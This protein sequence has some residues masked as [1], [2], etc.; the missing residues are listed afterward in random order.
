[1]PPGPPRLGDN[2][3]AALADT[4]PQRK[5]KKREKGTPLEYPSLPET[6]APN[7]RYVVITTTD[8]NKTLDEYSCFAI[9]RGLDLISKDILSISPLRDGSLLLLVKDKNIAKK[10]TETKELV[11]VCKVN[12]KLHEH[13]NFTKGTIYAPYLNKLPESEIIKELANDGVVDVYKYE[14]MVDGKKEKTGVML[15]TFDLY[16]VPTKLQVTYHKSFVREYYPNPMRCKQCQLL[17]HTQKR[18]KNLPACVNCNLPPHSPEVCTRTC[19]AN[20]N[21]EHPSSSNK[22]KK[23]KQQKDILKIKTKQKCTMREAIRLHRNQTINMK[24][25][26]SYS[27]TLSNNNTSIPT[28]Q[29]E[30]TKNTPTP[31]TAQITSNTQTTNSINRSSSPQPQESKHTPSTSRNIV[32]PSSSNKL[33]NSSLVSKTNNTSLTTTTCINTNLKLHSNDNASLTSKNNKHYLTAT[34]TNSTNHSQYS[35][36]NTSSIAKNN[37]YLSP[38][39][40]N[41]HTSVENEKNMTKHNTSTPKTDPKNYS[42]Y[43]NTS[44]KSYS[45]KTPNRPSDSGSVHE[46]S[47]VQVELMQTDPV[48]D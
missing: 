34:T 35:S 18:C 39:T 2:Q 41:K 16:T 5:R 46:N 20:C 11:G 38:S 24:N 43:K 47:T 23:Y 7:P 33:S 8:P 6:Q 19:C 25:T 17:G 28:T 40:N 45:L 12:C 30:Q 14:R 3:F 36:S 31:S 10:F 13:L 29:P 27:E 48:S 44:D 22:C 32:T 42:L 15:L 1:M 4:S 9:Q 37:N 26:S 21:E